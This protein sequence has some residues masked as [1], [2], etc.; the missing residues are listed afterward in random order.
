[1]STRESSAALA[2]AL[3]ELSIEWDQTKA[4]WSD[5][6]AQDFQRAY[7]EELPLHMA[8]AQAAINEIDVLLRKVKSA[9]E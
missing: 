9:C 4:Y 8:H 5:V 6:K 3:K 2:Q 7:L 1:M